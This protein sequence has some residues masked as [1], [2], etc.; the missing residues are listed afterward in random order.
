MAYYI[1]NQMENPIFPLKQE[2]AEQQKEWLGNSMRQLITMV[3]SDDQSLTGDVREQLKEDLNNY[4]TAEGLSTAKSTQDRANEMVAKSTELLSQIVSSMDYLGDGLK[5]LGRLNAFKAASLI[6]ENGVA[7]V[8]SAGVRFMKGAM[9]VVLVSAIFSGPCFN[10]LMQIHRLGD[11]S[12]RPSAHSG[13]GTT[14]L[15][16]KGLSS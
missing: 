14:F 8:S 12:F 13:T 6:V 9:L 7:K 4:A 15:A 10:R 3:L 1:K 16:H 5:A 11:T 2:E